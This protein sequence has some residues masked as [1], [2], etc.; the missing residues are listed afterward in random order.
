MIDDAT[1]DKWEAL[2]RARTQG[3]WFFWS[4]DRDKVCHGD[5]GFP[6]STFDVCDA[7]ESA[8]DGD[9]PF[10]AESSV[11]VP[12]LLAEV[13]RLRAALALCTADTLPPEA[14]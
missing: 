5:E 11:M 12:A 8:S 7:G 3:R 2:D 9:A 4:E 1:L 10:I 14:P 13:R 6:C